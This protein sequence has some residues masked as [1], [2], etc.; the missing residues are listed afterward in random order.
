MWCTT[1]ELNPQENIWDEIREKIFKNYACTIHNARRAGNPQSDSFGSWLRTIRPGIPPSEMVVAQALRQ[2]F[3][4]LLLVSSK[5]ES[6]EFSVVSNLLLTRVVHGT[7]WQ[8]PLYQPLGNFL[9]DSS[10]FGTIAKFAVTPEGPQEMDFELGVQ[11][12]RATLELQSLR[13]CRID[14]RSARHSKYEDIPLNRMTRTRY[15]RDLY[16]DYASVIRT[17]ILAQPQAPSAET[18]KA[19]LAQ[20]ANALAAPVPLSIGQKVA[21]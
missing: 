21:L 14:R 15:S 12:E 8:L 16:I 4:D 9:A 5:L 18:P 3:P 7:R 17:L 19:T 10:N 6:A 11:R 20:A 2:T 1:F 13:S